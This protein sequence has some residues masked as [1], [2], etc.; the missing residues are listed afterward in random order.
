MDGFLTKAAVGGFPGFHQNVC[1]RNHSALHP[2]DARKY[3]PWQCFGG[4]SDPFWVVILHDPRF[5]CDLL[6]D[7]GIRSARSLCLNQPGMSSFKVHF[8]PSTMSKVYWGY[9]LGLTPQD[10]LVA[11]EGFSFGMPSPPGHPKR[12]LLLGGGHTPKV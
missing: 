4:T 9:N 5:Q 2:G 3:R 6:W 7:Q 10:A 8:S 11:Y 1:E 12:S